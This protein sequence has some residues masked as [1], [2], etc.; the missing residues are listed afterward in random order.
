MHEIPE[1][2]QICALTLR[3]MHGQV[4]CIFACTHTIMYW[5]KS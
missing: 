5:I 4:H 3:N 1:H 2:P